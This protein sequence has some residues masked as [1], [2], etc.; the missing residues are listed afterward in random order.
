MDGGGRRV[1][2]KERTR[3][4]AH[5]HTHTHI[6]RTATHCGVADGGGP[7]A[8]SAIL[9]IIRNSFMLVG[10]PQYLT[11]L[12]IMYNALIP[13]ILIA[14]EEAFQGPRPFLSCSIVGDGDGDGDGDH[15]AVTMPPRSS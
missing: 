1:Q 14:A 2:C 4:Y 13:A 15:H 6:Y 9:L 10:L 8:A 11:T 7:V 5:T 12:P 3:I